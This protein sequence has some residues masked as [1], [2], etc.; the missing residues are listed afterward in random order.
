MLELIQRAPT[1]MDLLKQLVVRQDERKPFLSFLA[2]QILMKS[3]NMHMGL[4]QRAV[5]IMLY[6]N[7][8]SKEVSVVFFCIELK[9][10]ITVS[11]FRCRGICSH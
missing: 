11:N 8:T 2:S 10:K 7:G 4:V 3:H 5:S 6:G 9:K 1:L